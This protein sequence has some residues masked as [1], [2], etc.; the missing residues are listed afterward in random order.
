[1]V[2]KPVPRRI[3][4]SR[5]WRR[6]DLV[7]TDVSEERIASIFR[8]EKSSAATCSRWFFARGYL[9]LC[10]ESQTNIFVGIWSSGTWRRVKLFKFND[11]SEER[12]SSIFSDKGYNPCKTSAICEWHFSLQGR[13]EVSFE[14]V[15][16]FFCELFKIL[17]VSKLQ[18]RNR[19]LWLLNSICKFSK[20]SRILINLSKRCR[21]VHGSYRRP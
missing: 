20:I 4:S 19:A 6:V 1:M 15:R 8:V 2:K 12:I 18:R 17:S 7:W 13:R 9:Y 10:L 21:D 5:M 11:V 16:Y 14:T 3:L